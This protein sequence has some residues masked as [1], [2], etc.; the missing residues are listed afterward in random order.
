MEASPQQSNFVEVCS[1]E[2]LWEGEM[3]CFRVRNS[4][5]LW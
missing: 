1:V 2:D 4:A 5:I 3:R